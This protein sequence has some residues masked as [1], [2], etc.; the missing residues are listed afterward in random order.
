[1]CTTHYLQS[2][3]QK[4]H[5][6]KIYHT[7]KSSIKLEK[8][9]NQRPESSFATA[10]RTHKYTLPY[11]RDSSVSLCIYGMHRLKEAKHTRYQSRKC[12]TNRKRSYTR[13][14]K[15]S[16]TFGM[17]K[18]DLGAFLL[19]CLRNCGRNWTFSDVLIAYGGAWGMQCYY[20]RGE[21]MGFW[22]CAFKG[23]YLTVKGLI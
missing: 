6:T 1:M 13:T 16:S 9:T 20:R 14:Y 11:S 23:H 15:G 18:F 21:S 5:T 8:L 2:I 10:Q 3:Q 19:N 22:R 17:A 4:P 12:T 7:S